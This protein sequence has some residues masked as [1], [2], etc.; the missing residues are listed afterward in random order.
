MIKRTVATILAL[1]ML[2]G[3]LPILPASTAAYAESN[4]KCGDNITW[5]LDS[6]GTLT[7]TGFGEMSDFEISDLAP[8]YEQRES[9]K[10]VIFI[11]SGDGITSIGDYAFLDCL[12]LTDVTPPPTL[13]TVGDNAFNGCMGLEDFSLPESVST[14]GE[15]AFNSCCELTKVPS[16]SGLKSVTSVGFAAFA[17]CHKFTEAVFP[18]LLNAVPDAFYFGCSGLTS[19][20]IP[21]WVTEVGVYSFGDCSSLQEVMLNTG[22][23]ELKDY[24]FHNCSALKEFFI[25]NPLIIG[26]DVFN[27]C[28]SAAEFYTDLSESDFLNSS[29]IDDVNYSYEVAKH[30]YGQ[31]YAVALH[32]NGGLFGT[33][34][35]PYIL[36]KQSDNA[37]TVSSSNDYIPKKDGFKF[38]GWNTKPDGSGTAYM[39]GDS[40]T[41]NA[42][43][44]LYAQW[45]EAE[46]QPKESATRLSGSSRNG[47]AV[48]ISEK[49]EKSMGKCNAVVLANGWNF[50]DAL[51][52]GPLAY[53]LDAP[54]LLITGDDNDAETYAEIKRLGVS[55]IIILGGTGAVSSEVDAKLSS[56]GYEVH[57]IA[58]D[59]RFETAVKIAENMDNIYGK[60]SRTSFFTYS[61]NYPDA[62]A[63][64]GIAARNC[65]PILY[66]DSDGVLD[67]ATEA[68]INNCRFEKGFIIGGTGAISGN[69]EGNIKKAGAYDVD[70]IYGAT[71]Y[72]TCLELFNSS[73]EFFTGETVCVSTGVNFP[74]ALA[75]GVLAACLKAPMLLVAPDE[76]L[77]AAQ[78]NVIMQYDNVYIFGGKVAIPEAIENELKTLVS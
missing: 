9:I 27:S 54:I 65:S 15:Y 32:P 53:A 77:S 55:E 69:A 22:V 68:Y 30:Y 41:A 2:V 58:G 6:A 24:A 67:S 39:P 8:W 23:T 1:V 19:V 74:D 17:Y 26:A 66:L 51:A 52:G 21:E 47:T 75:G 4:G 42:T 48:A 38:I 40:Y 34:G 71:R 3:F 33:R 35:I 62:L 49:V 56:D 16:D 50:A 7:V 57:R 13:I 45:E 59:T 78:R 76:P 46:T 43:L 44:N 63:V 37:F 70:R 60:H 12:N 29:D 25:T 64:S 73:K 10:K 5:S 18:P 28:P 14:I 31:Y 11:N 72:E 20:V 36:K 61:H